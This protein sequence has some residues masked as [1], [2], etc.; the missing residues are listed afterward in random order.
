MGG[1][2]SSQR[3]AF[4]K[5]GQLI[6]GLSK[7]WIGTETGT[8]LPIVAPDNKYYHTEIIYSHKFTTHKHD[9]ENS[10]NSSGTLST[11]SFR[12]TNIQNK[13]MYATALNVTLVGRTGQVTVRN[14]GDKIDVDIAMNVTGSR[15]TATVKQNVL[16]HNNAESVGS[17]YFNELTF[18]GINLPMRDIYKY[19]NDLTTI[20]TNGGSFTVELYYTVSDSTAF[21]HI[22]VTAP[23]STL[24]LQ[25]TAIY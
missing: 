23:A 4:L 7:A 1:D 13:I 9:R 3:L 16:D 21:R 6:T 17:I 22:Y 8:I 10:Y 18:P 25:I 19:G 15:G 14:E 24:T 12:V 5:S 2:I 20:D 11:G